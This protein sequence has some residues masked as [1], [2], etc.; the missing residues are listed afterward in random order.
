MRSRKQVRKAFDHFVTTLDDCGFDGAALTLNE[1]RQSERVR[2]RYRVGVV[3]P[4]S[5][6]VRALG[7]PMTSD[8]AVAAFMFASE[9]VTRQKH[10]QVPMVS[11]TPEARAEDG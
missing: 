2:G 6:T 7:D 8:E 4:L 10:H 9:I 5:A 11:V 1:F 3:E